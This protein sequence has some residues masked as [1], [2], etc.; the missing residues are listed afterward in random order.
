METRRV[1]V[2]S[3]P[4][5]GSTDNRIWLALPDRFRLENAELWNLARCRSCG[6]AFLV[7]LPPLEA[8]ADYYPAD[9]YDPFITTAGTKS[10]VDRLYVRLRTFSLALRFRRL[11]HPKHGNRLLDVGC[12]TG[13]FLTRAKQ[14]GWNGAGIDVSP[15]AV[16]AVR[17]AG[18]PCH[19][20]DLLSYSAPESAFHA[21]TFWHS[22]E[23]T[24]QPKAVLEKAVSL[25]A[26]KGKIVIA[27]P[28]ATS[29][30]ARIYRENWIA[31]DAPRHCVMFTP[32]SLRQLAEDAGLRV[33]SVSGL[34]F[35]LA[36][37]LLHSERLIKSRTGKTSLLAPFRL[38]WAGLPA[39]VGG[40]AGASVIVLVAEKP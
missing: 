13:E 4:V 6:A 24:S 15:L 25:L 2:D 12:G 29:W 1:S 27:V 30:D 31:Y 3:C 16:E 9:G 7:Q 33:R 38:G 5:C 8:M 22:L 32:E 14:S 23:H 35:D 10:F 34:A 37:N 21:I 28:N 19:Q 17:K 11:G 40:E 39:L 26:P 36:Y 18:F 20:G